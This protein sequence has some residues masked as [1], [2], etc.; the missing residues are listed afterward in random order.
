MWKK[1]N[2][3]L[4]PGIILLV[5]MGVFCFLNG[6]CQSF[7][8]DEMASVGFVRTGVSL[9][10]MLETYL[11]AE[12]NLPL[13]PALLYGVYRIAPYGEQFLLIPSIL[14]C[15]SGIVFMAMA[16]AKLKGK[17]AG[18]L[19]L[20]MGVSSSAVIGQGAWEVRCYGMA[21]SLSALVL[22]LYIKRHLENT[23]VLFGGGLAVFLWT[24]WFACV[25]TAFYFAVDFILALM[26]KISWKRLLSYVPGI[27]LFLP[28]FAISFYNRQAEFQSFWGEVPQWKNM[29]WTILFYLGGN[30]VFWY[31]C[32]VTGI[33]III[34]ALCQIRKPYSEK[35]VKNLL[36]AICVLATGWV[37]AVIFFYS[38]YVNPGGSLYIERY[39]MVIA[40][41]ILLITA[42]GID[43]FL[44]IPD[45]VR[46]ADIFRRFSALQKAGIWI[47]RSGIVVLLVWT[48]LKCYRDE[49]I[50]IR[51]PFQPFREASEYLVEEK[52]IWDE[53]SLFIGSNRYCMLDGFIDYYFE[54]R[55]Y[56]PPFNTIDG[57]VHTEQESRF[58]DNYK[59]ITEQEL[60]SYNRIYCLKIHMGIAD[61]LEQFLQEN[62]D[63]VKEK[64]DNGIEIWEKKSR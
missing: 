38:R 39:F 30:R 7:W 31:L 26:G 64:E 52:G 42:L 24:H 18:F 19:A 53:D 49:Y 56:E 47:V 15:L 61:E 51:K 22:Y 3:Y 25:L 50:I 57:M 8:A 58:Y 10:E 35:K 54:K 63:K 20:C 45:R 5:W 1:E 44:D 28:W 9:K 46:E 37:I 36:S 16:A 32:L 48:F 29:F 60:L 6:N 23:S 12:N 33:G 13:Y 34:C 2:K 41:H 59:E 4:I 14:F 27:V 55:G 17:R 43:Y 21:F 11:Y 62:Y 40:P